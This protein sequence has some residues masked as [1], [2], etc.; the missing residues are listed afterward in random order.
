[1]T[2]YDE[3]KQAIMPYMQDGELTQT[4]F[5]WTYPIPRDVMS[6][7]ELPL[8]GIGYADSNIPD[9]VDVSDM[10][11]KEFRRIL[12]IYGYKWTG[13]GGKEEYATNEAMQSFFWLVRFKMDS[14]YSFKQ[15]LEKFNMQNIFQY[16][17]NL[18]LTVNFQNFGILIRALTPLRMTQDDT[19]FRRMAIEHDSTEV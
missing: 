6:L 19:I 2:L 5:Y 9:V 1:M 18:S 7:K 3:I 17:D 15:F 14:V 8:L 13:N 12:M 4:T 16:N 11:A 10:N